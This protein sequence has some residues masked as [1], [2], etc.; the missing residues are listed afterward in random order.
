M[1]V[2]DGARLKESL[3]KVEGAVVEAHTLLVSHSK[4]PDL[5]AGVSFR[6]RRQALVPASRP[7][8]TRV[9]LRCR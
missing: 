1:E 7:R 5:A 6:I 2:Q 9:P 4:F 8:H 3:A